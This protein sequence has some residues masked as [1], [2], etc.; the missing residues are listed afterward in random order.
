MTSMFDTHEGT[1]RLSYVFLMSH[2]FSGSTLLTF[3]L[4]AHPAIATVG[5]MGIA[6]K[7]GIHPDQYLCSCQEL[8]RKC[9]F[10]IS[11]SAAMRKQ[12]FDF[13]IRQSG[14]LFDPDS[15]DL[16]DRLLASALRP[17]LIER[18]RRLAIHLAPAPR[19]RMREVISR[20][21]AFARIVCDLKGC[22]TFVDASKRPERAVRL[23]DSPSFDVRVVHLVR[24]ARAVAYSCT[25]NLR[26]TIADG[27]RSAAAMHDY[28]MRAREHFPRSRWLT[29][30]YEDLCTDVHGVLGRIFEF[31]GVPNLAIDDFRASEHHVIGNRMR[32]R[33]TSQITVDETWKDALRAADLAIVES[34]AG[35]ANRACGYTE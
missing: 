24:D 30:R 8:I 18:A 22:R 11:V 5:E 14:L 1:R 25:K 3:L 35:K 4:G 9:E 19:A 34:V 28:C 31:A 32:L 33:P 29:V 2:G 26:Y 23:L 15:H 12:G 10:W 27:A 6:P 13:D 21:E 17:R 16:S 7:S 20:N